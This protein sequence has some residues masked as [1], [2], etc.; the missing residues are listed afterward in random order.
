M[1]VVVARI[2]SD[3]HFPEQDVG[4]EEYAP[5]NRDGGTARTG[6]DVHRQEALA[7]P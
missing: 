4:T 1:V 6:Q 5:R 2:G 7:L 3:G